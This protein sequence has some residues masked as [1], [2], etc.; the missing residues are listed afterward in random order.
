M[1][2]PF[3]R[4]YWVV[5][6]RLLAGYYPG[7]PFQ[8]EMEAKLNALLD[9]GIT[10]VLNLMEADE[11]DWEGN[12][13]QPYASSL[14]L[15]ATQRGLRADCQ[16]F[17]ICDGGIPPR[18]QMVETL[19]AIDNANRA[20]RAVYVHCWGGKGRTGTVVGCYLARHGIASGPQALQKIIEL[21]RDE[22]RAHE[23][24][25]ETHV[26]RDYVMNWREA[27]EAGLPVG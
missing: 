21:R 8:S 25:P 22:A 10:V 3:P 2:T 9:A 6:G 26:Q 16:R 15:L 12:P 7:A 17:P 4:S 23:A 19:D 14:T 20:G 1:T 5:P 11:V 24:S 27:S 18:Q 13:F